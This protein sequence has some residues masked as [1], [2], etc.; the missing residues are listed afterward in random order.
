MPNDWK[1]GKWGHLWRTRHKKNNVWF[2]LT[3]ACHVQRASKDEWAKYEP[4]QM[5]LAGCTTVAIR[6]KT[7]ICSKLSTLKTAC[8]N[9]TSG[10]Q[11]PQMTG[12]HVV[13][14]DLAQPVATSK[15]TYLHM[16]PWHFQVYI[17]S[18]GTHLHINHAFWFAPS[19]HMVYIL[20]LGSTCRASQSQ[21][22]RWQ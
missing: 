18:H 11:P 22:R 2:Q 9:L 20:A 15:F 14:S 10:P 6:V 3:L 5:P 8:L 13:K 1:S 16:E 7:L 12:I 19:S 4:V 17:S 21:K